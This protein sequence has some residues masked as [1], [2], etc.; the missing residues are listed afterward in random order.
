MAYRADIEIA[1]RGAE[2]LNS[3]KKELDAASTAADKL[4]KQLGQDAAVSSLKNL[5]NLTAQAAST[6]RSAA[7]GTQAQTKAID[8]YV[9][10]LDEAQRAETKL[11]QSIQRRQ[12]ELGLATQTTKEAS[13]TR[14]QR[15][16]GVALGAGF[17]LLFGGG[18]GAVIGGAAG[19][20]VGGPA[21]FAA[22]IA[23]SAIGQQI[24]TFVV[25]IAKLGQALDPLTADL[26]AITAA[27]GL[28]GTATAEY[29]SKLE[30]SGKS[31][32]ALEVATQEL[33]F[34][35][36]VDGVNALKEFGNQTQELSNEWS[37]LTTQLSAALAALLSGPVQS[38]LNSIET[39]TALNIAKTSDDPELQKLSKDLASSGI[40]LFLGASTFNEEERLAIET[41]IVERVRELRQEREKE[42][43]AAKEVVQARQSVLDVLDIQ[44]NLA[45]TNRDITDEVVYSLQ[46][47][48]IEKQ[49]LVK[50]EEATQK[51]LET[52]TIELQKQI[53]LK[54]LQTKRA[55]A[56]ADAEERRVR[57]SRQ[58]ESTLYKQIE[59]MLL[60][61]VKA[62]EYSDGEEA[63][64]ARH[65]ALYEAISRQR[66][67]SL[68]VERELALKEAE[69]N[70]TVSQTTKLYDF[71]KLLLTDDLN[72]EK[73]LLQTKK[74]QLLLDEKI[75]QQ[76]ALRE[77][78]KPFRE[79]AQQQQVQLQYTKDYAKLVEDGVLPAEAERLAS[80]N[81]LVREQDSYYETQI[82]VVE[83]QIALTEATI[84]E[85]E[86]RGVAVT[87]LKKQLD[88]LKKQQEAAKGAAAE[89]PGKGQTDS[90]RLQAVVAELQGQLNE[91][92]DPINMLVSGATAIESAFSSAFTDVLTGAAS[93]E[94]GLSE[95]FGRIGEAFV[96]MAA[97]IIAKQLIL[98]AL[99]TVLNALGG[100]GS[101]GG[102][103]ESIDKT[104]GDLNSSMTKYKFNF[105]EGG[106]VTSPTSATIGEG[107]SSE[108]VI[109][110]SKMSGAMSRWNS[111]VRGD[112]LVSGAEPTGGAGGVALAEAPTNIVVEGGVL[113]FNDS[114]YIRQDQVPAIVKQASAAGE[115]KALR[116][117]QMSTATRKRIGL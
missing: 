111:G 8:A 96:S 95:M 59:Q 50:T 33:A 66:Y 78:V 67:A 11:Q 116:K 36:G 69:K 93:V 70:D 102:N 84:T 101:G 40:P 97:E 31:T 18:P 19:G 28:T 100:G 5:N 32:E 6:M 41:K 54:N 2:K 9:L 65:L 44:K 77:A 51:K 106:Y 20:L 23:L 38:L 80:F 55:K 115:A 15:L 49:A 35:V 110:E 68:E 16:S 17:P 99:Q 79:Y 74:D 43:F 48:L 57:T 12:K 45:A 113:N 62:A 112:A 61:S 13:K 3:L 107:S 22:Q 109:P 117:L 85:A 108:Y 105:A 1:V 58:I 37:I 63:S 21:G 72:L 92:T 86:A 47:Q 103:T 46:K 104:L 91:L 89:G 60:F 73:S 42:A 76:E 90:E 30:A 98:I 34:V 81:Q 56:L 64:L 27:A 52:Q 25:S 10:A 24:D 26:D 75:T 71:K 53:D 7:T 4:N 88:L 94:E 87:E 14:T 29:I 39:T 83:N 114:Q 82:K